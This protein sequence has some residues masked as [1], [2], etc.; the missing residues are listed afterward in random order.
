MNVQKERKVNRDGLHE[1]RILADEYG[2]LYA[3]DEGQLVE[4]IVGGTMR[5]QILTGTVV[6]AVEMSD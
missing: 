4:L 3:E 1:V 6:H 5:G 2:I